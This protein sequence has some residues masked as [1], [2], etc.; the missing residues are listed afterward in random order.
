MDMG[1]PYERGSVKGFGRAAAG[2]LVAALL[3]A[4][5]GCDEPARPTPAPAAEGEK[6][7]TARLET[8]I[9]CEVEE[10]AVEQVIQYVCDVTGL[11]QSCEPA[12]R[13]AGLLQRL[14]SVSQRDAAARVVLDEGLKQAKLGYR[15]ENDRLVI[16]TRMAQ[17]KQ[18]IA[19]ADLAAQRRL[20]KAIDCAF[21]TEIGLRDLMSFFKDVSGVW[22][23]FD[24][25]ALEN[26]FDEFRVT[27]EAKDKSVAEIMKTLLNAQDADYRLEAGVVVIFETKPHTPV[28]VVPLQPEEQPK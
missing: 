10:L 9:T 22:M 2:G 26:G 20:K 16:C 24:D 28:E 23:E 8:R 25:K 7:A 3:L 5:L 21:T 14:V 6:S 18:T 15:V 1:K 13:E 11:K 17:D 27:C 19:E 4:T 12:V